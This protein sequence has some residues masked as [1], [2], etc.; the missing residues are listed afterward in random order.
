MT[1]NANGAL[2]SEC[3]FERVSVRGELVLC[4]R[5]E[6]WTRTQISHGSLQPTG[7]VWSKTHPVRVGQ[8]SAL[9]A[10]LCCGAAW[11]PCVLCWVCDKLWC[12]TLMGP[13]HVSTLRTMF[14]QRL[15]HNQLQQEH[16]HWLWHWAKAC[17]TT[18]FFCHPSGVKITGPLHTKQRSQLKMSGSWPY[19]LGIW[20]LR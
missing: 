8:C 10:A 13:D 11:R 18:S 15:P 16:Q 17:F 12:P 6:D 19:L 9:W 7:A 5:C 14:C 4:F 2:G 3:H 20:P 1:I